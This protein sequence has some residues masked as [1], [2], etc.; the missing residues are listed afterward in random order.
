MPQRT[1]R[2]ATEDD[3]TV[4]QQVLA[5]GR[6]RMRQAGNLHQW[7]GGYPSD[8]ILKEDIRQG[9]S[10][11]VEEDNRMIA[12]FVLAECEEPTY[13]RIFQGQWLDDTRPYATIHRIAALPEV[14]GIFQMVVQFALL[15]MDSLRIDTHQDNHPMRHMVTS[16]G[17]T[18]C[19]IILLADGSERMAYQLVNAS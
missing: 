12:V 3:I 14:H 1:I 2:H 13:R 16:N 17:F 4:M 7:T 8:D 18:Y 19:G 5:V 6:E 10:Y 15:R 9:F 11:V